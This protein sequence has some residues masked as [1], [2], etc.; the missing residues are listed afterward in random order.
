MAHHP[1]NQTLFSDIF[2]STHIFMRRLSPFS[3]QNPLKMDS[4]KIKFILLYFQMCG[5]CYFSS[6]N[7]IT[8]KRMKHFML[9]W[10]CVH[11]LILSSIVT[12]AIYYGSYAFVIRDIITTAIDV[13][14][15]MLPVLSHYITI[16]ESFRTRNVK[17]QFW[18]RIRYIDKFLLFTSSSLKQK[19][20]NRYSLKLVVVLVSTMTVDLFVLIRVRSDEV[21]RNY[22][23]VSLYT[24]LMCRSEVLFCVLFIETLRYQTD[25]VTI[26]L[27]EVR[28]T[29][30]NQFN[31]LRCCKK[32]FEVIWLSV[33]DINRAFG[34]WI[35]DFFTLKIPNF[36]IQSI[37]FN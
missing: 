20:I 6:L 5:L 32:A 34:I 18:A 25:M 36:Y 12:L 3:F 27:K 19:L 9:I 26:R 28:Y 23:I 14:Q 30:K 35:F 17:D 8:P 2:T 22:I 24:F 33:D 11:L 15:W 4:L 13:L 29:C 7:A 16:I 1:S 10:S 37:F 21:W 31:L